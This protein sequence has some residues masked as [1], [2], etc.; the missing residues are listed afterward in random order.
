MS[1]SRKPRREPH[2]ERSTRIPPFTRSLDAKVPAENIFLVELIKEFQRWLA[3]SEATDGCV[4][5]ATGNTEPL[6]RRAAGLKTYVHL[7]EKAEGRTPEAGDASVE[8]A[9]AELVRHMDELAN[10]VAGYNGMMP[11]GVSRDILAIE[12]RS[13]GDIVRNSRDRPLIARYALRTLIYVSSAFASGA[14]GVYAE[15]CLELLTK[16]LGG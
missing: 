8:A 12:I 13:A 5:H 14:I 7:K 1:K 6:A 3:I 16:F 11:P 10:M 2:L 9:K 15:K 4:F